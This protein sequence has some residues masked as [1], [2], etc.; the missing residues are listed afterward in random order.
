PGEKTNFPI[1][2]ISIAVV[3]N[4]H[5]TLVN[6]IQVGELA[7]DLKDYAKSLPGSSYAVDKR[8]DNRQKILNKAPGKNK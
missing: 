8:T 7:A 1:M 6:H 5:R 3:T 4:Q 2:T